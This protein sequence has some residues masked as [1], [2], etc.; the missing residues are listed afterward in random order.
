MAT[1][2]LKFRPSSVPEAKGTLYYQVIHKRK[3]KWISTK[4]HIYADE[5][6]EETMTIAIANGERKAAL[7]LMQRKIDWAFRRWQE[8]GRASCRER[9]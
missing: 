9:V 8:I 2:R 1:I 6:N 5:W 3:V 4:H 7:A